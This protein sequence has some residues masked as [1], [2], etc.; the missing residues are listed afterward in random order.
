MDVLRQ[1]VLSGISGDYGMPLDLDVLGWRKIWRPASPKTSKSI[2]RA[3]IW[4]VIPNS[5]KILI[6]Y[7]IFRFSLH[8]SKCAR[9]ERATI[10]GA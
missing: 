3:K 8:V 2:F 5:T 10:E 4:F 1:D 9:A 7:L 6:L